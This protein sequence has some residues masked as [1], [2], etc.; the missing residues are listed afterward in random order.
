MSADEVTSKTTEGGSPLKMPSPFSKKQER[1][2]RRAATWRWAGA[3][4]ATLRS[5]PAHLLSVERRRNAELDLTV[6]VMQA[7]VEALSRKV[8]QL[9]R[10][11]EDGPG[12]LVQADQHGGPA[13]V[14]AREG[15]CAGGDTGVGESARG[16]SEA[17]AVAATSTEGEADT[18]EAPRVEDVPE[19]EQTAV[20]KAAHSSGASVV[21]DLSAAA[22]AGKPFEVTALLEVAAPREMRAPPEVSAPPEDAAPGVADAPSGVVAPLIVAAPCEVAAMR[23]VETPREDAAPPEVAAPPEDAAPGVADA[24]RDDAAPRVTGATGRALAAHREW[25]RREHG[26][27]GEAAEALLR[28]SVKRRVATLKAARAQ[29]E[30]AAQI[31][32]PRV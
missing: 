29:D 14:P 12:Q 24:S 18:G 11:A 2:A 27:E 17:P 8:A 9:A 25:L 5:A 22:A 15:D 4:E 16:G 7:Q 31:Q 1:S 30:Q 28:E 26:V 32:Q 23:E 21:E 3:Y 20:E 6:A 19:Q 10:A 13:A